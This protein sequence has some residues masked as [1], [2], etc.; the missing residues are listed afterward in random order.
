MTPRKDTD[1]WIE[2]SSEK[3]WSDQMKDKMAIWK[4][5]MPRLIDYKCG[6]AGDNFYNLG[7]RGQ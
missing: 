5:R 1:F 2:S 6:V 4:S 7:N 3:R